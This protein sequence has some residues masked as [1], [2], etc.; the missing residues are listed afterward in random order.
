MGAAAVAIL[1]AMDEELAGVR[2]LTRVTRRLRVG[3]CAIALGQMEGFPVLLACTG[4]GA[5]NAER[6]AREVYDRFPVVGAVIVGVSG[7]LSPALEPGTVLA[8]RDVVE[9]GR[10]APPP[11]PAWLR[12]ALRDTGATAATFLSSRDVLCTARDKRQAYAGLPPGSV[13]SVDLESAAFAR[14]AADGGIP[15]VALRAIADTAEETLPLDFS[16]LRDATGA[17]DRRRVALR[18]LRRPAL[19]VP[20]WRLRRRV[21]L[22]SENLRRAVR[23]LLAGGLP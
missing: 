7:G 10:P 8:A 3:R 6:G 18:V 19:V 22:C 14:A 17:I 20:L 15:Y 23:A 12:R 9:E 21:G 13:A 16:V 2:A 4:D 11:D 1:A 5:R